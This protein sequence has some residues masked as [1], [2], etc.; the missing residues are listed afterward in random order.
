MVRPAPTVRRPYDSMTIPYPSS[1][2]RLC[3]HPVSKDLK[4]EYK[5]AMKKVKDTNVSRKFHKKR[6]FL[7]L[8]SL[9]N[10]GARTIM[11]P[12]E[13]MIVREELNRINNN[14]S[15]ASSSGDESQ[16]RDSFHGDDDEDRIPDEL[17]LKYT[18]DDDE[19]EPVERNVS[20][21]A[22]PRSGVDSAAARR[23]ETPDKIPP[24][25]PDETT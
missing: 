23:C 9:Q 17:L 8:G 21:A 19:D 5:D 12:D 20:P 3:N 18:K 22:T 11:L 10:A 6:F 13:E 14:A 7:K 15:P 16:R 4:R 25:D 2:S 24:E 1:C